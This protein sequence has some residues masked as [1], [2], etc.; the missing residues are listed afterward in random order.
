MGRPVE[1]QILARVG[2]L[3]GIR[4][5]RL[6]PCGVN[7]TERRIIMAEPLIIT[8]TNLLHKYREPNTKQV[9]EFLAKHKD[10]KVFQRRAKTLDKLFLLKKS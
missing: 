9:R 10:D 8:Y 4:A 3:D 2:I 1:D 5:W 7:H 6:Q